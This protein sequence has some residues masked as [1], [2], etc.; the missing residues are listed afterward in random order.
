M[1]RAYTKIKK[2]LILRIKD[3]MLKD[4][5]QSVSVIYFIETGTEILSQ[6]KEN[7]LLVIL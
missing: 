7:P 1:I 3:Y 5:C 4:F 2:S 6:S